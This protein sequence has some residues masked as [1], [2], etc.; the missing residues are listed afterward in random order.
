MILEMETKGLNMARSRNKKQQDMQAKWAGWDTLEK[1]ESHSGPRSI[2]SVSEG[3]I[4][5]LN[6]KTFCWKS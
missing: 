5:P 1:A 2:A 6:W 3:T 4:G